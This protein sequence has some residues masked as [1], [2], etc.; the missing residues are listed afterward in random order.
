[1][2]P[3]RS[4][5]TSAQSTAPFIVELQTDPDFAEGVDG[6]ALRAAAEA[7]LAQER[8]PGA[9]HGIVELTVVVTDNAVLRDLNRRYRGV[10]AVTDVLSFPAD[11]PGLPFVVPPN[12]TAYLGDVIIAYPQ[13]EAQAR[14]GGHSTLAE[15]QL[16][17]VHGVLHLLGYDHLTAA[18][19]KRMWAAQAQ[20]LRSVG[21]AISEPQAPTLADH[22]P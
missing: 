10:D 2:T 1:V 20:A 19:R 11:E 22:D 13:A 5:R 16:L 6:A 21:A 7:V 18:D 17:A 15:L 3:A 9:G 4:R 14:A 12:Q 8:S